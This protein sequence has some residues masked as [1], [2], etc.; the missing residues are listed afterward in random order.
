MSHGAVSPDA[1]LKQPTTNEAA[2]IQQDMDA[3]LGLE[4]LNV[5]TCHTPEHLGC[6]LL[7]GAAWI[8]LRLLDSD[9]CT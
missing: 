8:E 5:L 3:A 2:V 6:W 1:K 4:R 7:N 9:G